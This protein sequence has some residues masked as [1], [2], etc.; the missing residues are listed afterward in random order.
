MSETA[1]S[2]IRREL[3]ELREYRAH[4]LPLAEI[5]AELDALGAPSAA[6]GRP[7]FLAE[8]FAWL[9]QQLNEKRLKPRS[10]TPG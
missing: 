9:R 7:L 3:A 6:G 1:T 2:E 10:P 4:S 5:H 8:R